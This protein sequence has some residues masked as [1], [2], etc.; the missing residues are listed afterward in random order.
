M[1]LYQIQTP[2]FEGPLDLLL[3]LIEREELDVTT[4][5]LAR[6]TDQYLKHLAQLEQRKARDLADFLVVAAKLVLIKSAAL[7]PS[8]LKSDAEEEVEDAGL[9][10][11][12][13]LQIY[14][15]FKEVADLLH[16]REESG[17]HTYIRL[18]PS[19][20]RA[21]EPDLSDVSLQDLF[22]LAQ[23]ALE[24]AS[25]PPVDDVVAPITVTIDEQMGHIQR[26]LT[27]TP[28]LDFRS[29]LSQA[30]TRIE[31]IVT[32]LAVLELIKQDQIVVRQKALF[33]EIVIRRPAPSSNEAASA[34][35]NR[36]G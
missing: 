1:Q 6:V 21:P 30:T 11:L 13:R 19:P 32:L 16:D 15:R 34:A 2:T 14:K 27:R 5:A 25:G 22:S 36:T 7:L 35:T 31:I 9:D 23:E 8:S 26:E 28:E 12:Q 20:R 29:L 10:L 24:V 17:L 3:R 18:V 33:G 4:V